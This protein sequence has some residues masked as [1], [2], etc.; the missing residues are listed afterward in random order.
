VR[1]ARR[2]FRIVGSEDVHTDTVEGVHS[3]LKRSI[4]GSYHHLSVKH[5]PAYVDEMEWRYNNRKNPY[6]F[7]NTLLELIGAGP[8][9]YKELT[10]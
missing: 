1:C 3:L 9:E 10:A 5:L 6:L 8:M 4:I 7:R 2:W